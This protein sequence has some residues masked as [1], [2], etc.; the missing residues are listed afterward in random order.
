MIGDH[1][2]QHMQV[3]CS[4]VTV[5]HAL[6]FNAF[7]ARHACTGEAWARCKQQ[8]THYRSN[9]RCDSAHG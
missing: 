4:A 5:S 8:I 2:V 3:L 1:G 7:G 9:N 6:L